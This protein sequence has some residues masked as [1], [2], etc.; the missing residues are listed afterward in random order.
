MTPQLSPQPLASH[1]LTHH[2]HSP[3]LTLPRAVTW[4]WTQPWALRPRSAQAM[5]RWVL[6]GNERENALYRN[7]SFKQ[8]ASH[9]WCPCRTQVFLSRD[10]TRLAA[11]MVGAWGGCDS[12]LPAAS[13]HLNWLPQC[14]FSP[15]NTQHPHTCHRPCFPPQDV[16]RLLH[17]Y[18]SG[19]GYFTNAMFTVGAVYA[20]VGEE[21]CPAFTPSNYCHPTMAP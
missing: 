19:L 16:F 4:A 1:A 5:R 13:W 9:D 15:Y 18:W 2:T 10:L 6:K 14:S 3:L 8:A 7:V 20:Q 21:P 11:R 12:H 17:L